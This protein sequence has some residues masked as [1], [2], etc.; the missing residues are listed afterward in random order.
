VFSVA[1]KN[2]KHLIMAP[3]RPLH[4]SLRAAYDLLRA[5]PRPLLV[6]QMGKVGL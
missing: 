2:L 6:Y 4:H 1:S 5:Q 3:L